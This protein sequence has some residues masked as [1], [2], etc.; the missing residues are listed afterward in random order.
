[1]TNYTSVLGEGTSVK[2]IGVFTSPTPTQA[3]VCDFIFRD[4]YSVFD[5]GKMPMP[6]GSS[7]DNTTIV[8]MAALNFEM[9]QRRGLKTHYIGMVDDRGEIVSF[10]DVADRH[11]GPV[12]GPQPLPNKIRVRYVNKLPVPFAEGQYDYSAF[13]EPPAN[14][15]VYP[16]EFIFRNSL[17]KDASVWKRIARG[18]IS[19][20]DFGLPETLKPGDKLPSPVLDYSTKF[21]SEDRYLRPE[22]AMKLAGLS[23]NRFANINEAILMAD[24]LLTDDAR[25]LGFVHEDGKVEMVRLGDNEDAFGDVAGTWHED[26]YLFGPDGKKISKQP[27]RDVNRLLN[28][29]WAAEID[30]RK[31][32]ARERG[33]KDWKSLVTVQPKPLPPEFFAVMNNLFRAGT[34]RYTGHVFYPD[35]SPSLEEAFAEFDKFM[36]TVKP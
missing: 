1:M 12:G 11:L 6:E 28:P 22:E 20:S 35:A 17:G 21:E 13:Q 3:G 5:W 25:S 30:Q 26:R 27:Y 4:V 18:E 31:A 23:P 32:E 16:L 34:N 9:M 10:Q 2:Q 7:V 8:L 15:F 29:E 19:L 33:I 24:R 14:N 36:A